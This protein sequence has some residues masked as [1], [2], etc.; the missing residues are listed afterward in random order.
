MVPAWV[1]SCGWRKIRIRNP[2]HAGKGEN[3][4]RTP[5]GI[6][7][8]NSSV[9]LGGDWLIKGGKTR[10]SHGVLQAIWWPFSREQGVP[11]LEVRFSSGSVHSSCV[12]NGCR[13]HCP[14]MRRRAPE[15]CANASPCCGSGKF[16]ENGPEAYLVILPQSPKCDFHNLLWGI[17]LFCPVMKRANANSQSAVKGKESPATVF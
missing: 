8:W 2:S 9:V 6:N 11:A 17:F 3:N 12:S 4:H 10:S 16:W 14:T 13:F 15:S 7:S 5:E 1:S